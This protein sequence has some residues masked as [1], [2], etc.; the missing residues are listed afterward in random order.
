MKRSPARELPPKAFLNELFEYD[1]GTGDLTWKVRP[2][3]HFKSDRECKRWNTKYSGMPAGGIKVSGKFRD[4]F[5]RIVWIGRK[6]YTASR[7]IMVMLG[8][9]RDEIRSMQVDHINGDSLDNR[10]E[11]LRL[12]TP[13][14]NSQNMRMRNDNRSG[15]TGVGFYVS[16][17]RWMARIAFNGK[18]EHLGYFETFEKAC[19]ARWKRERELGFTDRHG[20][21]A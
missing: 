20:R 12:A 6:R 11:N 15:V 8:Y 18:D 5:Q 4:Y 14:T 9:S 13:A 1:A 17:N 3:H 21:A 7:L 19:E 10:A 16:T 2:R